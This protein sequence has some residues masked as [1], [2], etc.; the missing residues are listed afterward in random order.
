M[1]GGSAI[2]VFEVP[3]L[4]RGK[5]RHRSFAQKGVVVHVADRKTESYEAQVKW[6]ARQAMGASGLHEL[7][8]GPL[9]LN[10]TAF[11]LPNKQQAK[12]MEKNPQA[13]HYS[14]AKPDFDNLGKIVADALN[15]IAYR[16]DAIIADGRV[17][18]RL[19]N[20]G[21]VVVSIGRLTDG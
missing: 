2:L 6:F 9:W 18:K 4:P 1:N 19:G 7:L 17:I 21:K 3:G 15:G 12:A 16:D 14:T 8:E 11:S 5:G 10:I 20:A 13:M